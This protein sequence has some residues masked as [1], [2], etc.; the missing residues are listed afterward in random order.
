MLVRLA[1][2]VVA[3]RLEDVQLWLDVVCV[4]LELVSDAL[5]VVFDVVDVAGG[6]TMS[7]LPHMSVV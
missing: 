3:V 7:T 4:R 1:L 6:R 2:D 5:V